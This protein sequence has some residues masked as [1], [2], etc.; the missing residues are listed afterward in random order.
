MMYSIS[1]I[2]TDAVPIVAVECAGKYY[3]VNT[4]VPG[5]ISRPERGTL[6]L[7][8]NWE[9]TE[10]ALQEA[11]EALAGHPVP[12]LPPPSPAD[13]AAPILY[14]SKIICT[15]TNYYDHLRKDMKIFDFDKSNHDILFFQKHQHAMVGSGRS[16]RYP[17]QSRQLDWEVE[18]AVIFG[19]AGRH[20]EPQHALSYVAGYSIGLDLSARDWQFN[21]RHPKQFD[22]I[23]GKS[24]DDSAPMGPGIVPARFV[25]PTRLELKLS[26]NG[27]LKQHS[28]TGEMI[29][30]I[31]EQI[32]ELSRHMSIRPGDVLFTGSPS[33]VGFA[34]QE[35]LA[36]GDRITAEITGLGSLRIDIISEDASAG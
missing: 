10:A 7:L 24:F 18:L 1:V 16:V 30:S 12:A 21:P 32:V 23:T 13:F 2:R 33:G 22:L 20:I 5:L 29:W 4:L 27:A 19:K 15:G 25:D 35:F 31:E 36:I 11:I 28:N 9:T 34:T 26:V 14:P 17:S 8:E 3:P 6:D